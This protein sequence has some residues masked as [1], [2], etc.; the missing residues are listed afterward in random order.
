LGGKRRRGEGDKKINFTRIKR[1]R[2]KK[3]PQK[4]IVWV[5]RQERVEE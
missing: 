4:R 1:G 5:A 3:T 2:A